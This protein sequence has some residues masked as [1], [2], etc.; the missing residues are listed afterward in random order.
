MENLSSV[1]A[2]ESKNDNT[3]DSLDELQHEVRDK[4]CG[5]D[6]ERSGLVEGLGVVFNVTNLPH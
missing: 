5:G 6:D 2:Y 1:S 3:A 4:L